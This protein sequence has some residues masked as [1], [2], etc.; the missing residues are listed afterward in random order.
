MR[1]SKDKG[2]CCGSLT[3]TLGRKETRT[4]ESDGADGYEFRREI[5]QSM[6]E[7][8]DGRAVRVTLQASAAYGGYV[9]ELFLPNEFSP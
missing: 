5:H 3:V 7:L 9:I 6:H 1:I 2:S 4:H 8:S